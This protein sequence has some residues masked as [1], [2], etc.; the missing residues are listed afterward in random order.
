MANCPTITAPLNNPDLT[1]VQYQLTQADADRTP[2]FALTQVG[3][4][5]DGDGNYGITPDG[6]PGY[7]FGFVHVY[8]ASGPFDYYYEYNLPAPIPLGSL[9]PAAAPPGALAFATDSTGTLTVPAFGASAQSLS[10]PAALYSGPGA[11]VLTAPVEA[12]PGAV[13]GDAGDAGGSLAGYSWDL[14]ALRPTTL[15]GTLTLTVNGASV[16]LPVSVST[17][18][19]ALASGPGLSLSGSLSLG[20]DFPCAGDSFDV[21]LA[22]TEATGQ[23]FTLSSAVFAVDGESGV[24]GAPFLAGEGVVG[25]RLDTTGMLPSAAMPGLGYTI[26]GQ[27]T[28]GTGETVQDQTA[29][30]LFGGIGPATP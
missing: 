22:V 25:S 8:S 14:S 3:V 23:G 19:T 20:T 28:A 13:V 15:S 24:F 10:L 29:M 17:M 27:A 30:Y 6:P 21:F 1:D 12:N 4:R 26:R 18:G 16:P 7:Q 2:Y 9:A 5:N 11:P